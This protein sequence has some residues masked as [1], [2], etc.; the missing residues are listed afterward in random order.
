MNVDP[1]VAPALLGR[2]QIEACE[3]G[4]VSALLSGLA[5]SSS[6]DLL[7]LRPDQWADDWTDDWTDDWAIDMVRSGR[8]SRAIYPVRVLEEAPEV[9]R[10]RAQAGEHVRVLAAVPSWLAIVGTSAALIPEE[11]GV[12]TERRL[13]VRQQA[14]ITALTF[15]FETLWERAVTVASPDSANVECQKV[16]RQ[17]LDQ[18]GSGAKDEQIARTLGLSLRTVRRRVAEMLDEL[19]VDSRFQAGAEAVRRGWV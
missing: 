16:R 15:L 1:P 7:W 9:L 2:E 5:T 6:R 11:W 12:H 17:L 14:M 13:V 8:R 4:D 19:G 10:A 18:L 3:R